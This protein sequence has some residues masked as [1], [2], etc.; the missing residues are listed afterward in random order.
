MFE[1]YPNLYL[2]KSN[3]LPSCID[4][5]LQSIDLLKIKEQEKKI[6]NSPSPK[7]N[8]NLP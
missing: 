7:R 8:S 1:F 2:E 3:L 4:N 6:L 5:F